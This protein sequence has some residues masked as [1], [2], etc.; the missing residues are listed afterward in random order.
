MNSSSQKSQITR[1]GKIGKRQVNTLKEGD[2]V[3]LSGKTCRISSAVSH[4]CYR[5]PECS[6]CY[7]LGRDIFTGEKHREQLQAISYVDVP[8]VITREYQVLSVQ[9]N[10]IMQLVN[11]SGE[12]KGDLSLPEG[13]LGQRIIALVSQAPTNVVIVE[14]NGKATVTSIGDPS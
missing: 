14:V 13:D 5:K 6:S 3:T 11:E 4:N 10:G 2:F 7:I 1:P 12:P 8:K 9:E